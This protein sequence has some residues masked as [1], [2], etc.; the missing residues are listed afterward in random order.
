MYDYQGILPIII[1]SIFHG[2]NQIK[3]NHHG[4][5]GENKMGANISWYTIHALS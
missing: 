5:K 4:R 2:K 1:V 3:K